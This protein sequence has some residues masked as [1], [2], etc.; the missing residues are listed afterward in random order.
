Q[1]EEYTEPHW[2]IEAIEDQGWR[3]ERLDYLCVE[4]ERN[5][6]IIGGSRPSCRIEAK[7]MFRRIPSAPDPALDI[8][9]G[10]TA[11]L[12]HRPAR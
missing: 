8:P 9:A 2:L 6:N 1:A 7:L 5:P 11:T 10:V 3:L 4:L 12:R